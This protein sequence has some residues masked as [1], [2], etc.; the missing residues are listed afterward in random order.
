MRIRTLVSHQP[1]SSLVSR[2]CFGNSILSVNP[3]R[4]PS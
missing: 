1:G 4:L 2:D 3:L